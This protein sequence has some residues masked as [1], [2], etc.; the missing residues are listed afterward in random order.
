MQ[1]QLQRIQQ[2][3]KPLKLIE[4]RTVFGGEDTEFSVYDTYQRAERVALSASNPLYCGM[5][6][7]RK[8]IHFDSYPLFDF[9]PGESL[10]VPPDEEIYID[11]PEAAFED[12][13]KCLTVEIETRRLYEILGRMNE[14]MPRS[15]DS[16]E[17]SYDPQNQYHFR[18]PQHLERV[19]SE[20]VNVFTENNPLRDQLIDVKVMELVIRMM[21]HEASGRWL[22]QSQHYT[23]SNGLSKAAEF[24]KANL[25]RGISIEELSR[26]ACMSK[27]NLFRY[28]KN[29]FGLT[30]VQYINQL[31][32]ERACQLLQ[33]PEHSVTDVCFM[34]GFTSVSYFINLFK[35][36]RGLT[37]K[38]YQAQQRQTLRPPLRWSSSQQVP[39]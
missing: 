36:I 20:L 1:Q 37:P 10:V 38:Q 14:R 29:E 13:T 17:W 35:S 9:L 8:V 4:N 2:A 21:Q 30:P 34:M 3:H 28:F 11:F 12:P 32:V 31:R 33:H 7:G 27:T 19:V 16:G 6:T 5:V 23:T 22:H 18:N 24:I 26:H 25:H 15:E 39:V